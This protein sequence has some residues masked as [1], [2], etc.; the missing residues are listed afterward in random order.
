MSGLDFQ[1]VDV[2][3]TG[4]L[5]TKTQGKL[6]IP[7]KWN[8]LE[9][10]TLS[11]DDTPTRRDGI[12]ALVAAATG[13][14][15]ATYNDELLV[16]KG[17]GVKSISTAGTDFANAVPGKLGFVNVAK[18]EIRRS[19]GMQEA[20]DVAT[21]GGL[22]CYVWRELTSAAVATG[23]NMSLLDEATGTQIQAN[24]VLHANTA[25]FCP[26]V[27]FCPGIVVGQGAFFIFY[28][29]GTSLYGRV[30]YSTSPTVLGAETAL[31]TSANLASLNFDA[32]PFGL[33][34]LLETTAMV[35]YGWADGTTSVRTIQVNQAAGVPAILTGP[36][37]IITEAALPIATLC[38]IGVAQFSAVIAVTFTVASA[39]APTLSGLAGVTTDSA[40]AVLTAATQIDATAPA[41]VGNCH[42]AACTDWSSSTRVA[43]FY[44][45]QMSFS[46]A[47]TAL[48]PIRGSVLLNNLTHVAGPV[49]IMN[50]AGF[51]GAATDPAGPQGPWIAGK[52]FANSTATFLPVCVLENYQGA[53]FTAPGGTRVTNNQQN[54]LFLLDCTAMSN[55]LPATVVAKA[56]Y[57]S[58]GVAAINNNPPRISTACSTPAPVSG[59]FALAC[60]ER[61]LL[62]FVDGFNISP[63]GVVRLTFT[64]NTTTPPI[65]TQLGELT[66]LA[67][68]SLTT[69][70]GGALVEHGFPL[71]PEG[72]SVELVAAGGAMTA[73]VHQVV[74]IAEW[75]DNAGERHQSKPSLA[76][77]MTVAANDRLRVRVPSL[78]L[79]Q[80]TGVMFVAYVTQAAGLTFNR[81]ATVATG[82]GG[83]ANDPTL[84]F[85]TLALIDAADATYASNELLYTQPNLAG[86][87][88]PNVAPGPCSALASH[89]NR[90]FFDRADQPCQFGFTQRY[91]N[92]LGLQCNPALGGSWDISGGSFVG[93]ASMDE[94]M[95]LFC[96][97]K[98]FVI[99][100]TG[101]DGS[102]G[103]SNYG[104]PQEISSDAGCV[105]ARSILKMPHGIIFK[106]A[107]G[108]YLL[109]RD[110]QVRYIGE[111]VAAFDANSVSSAVLLE[112]R[113]ECRFSST[114][115]TQLIYSY[116]V[117]GDGQWSTTVYRADSG[118]AVTN[119]AIADAIWWATGGYYAT[120][121]LVHGLN[122]DTAGVFLDQPGTSPAALAIPTTARTAWLRMAI[123]N[124][125]QRVRRFFLTGTSPNAPTSTLTVTVDFDDAYG[126]VVAGSYQFTV[127]YGT[128]FP[129][130]LVGS[131]VDIRH[132][133]IHQKC[134]SVSFTFTDTPTTANPAGVNLQALS[135][136]LGL[137]RGLKKLPAA[138]TV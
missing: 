113:M 16:V 19:T 123:I 125:Y 93:W 32:Q 132:K 78:L 105:D 34:G 83:T 20:L 117:K 115:G 130:F 57:G 70:D 112:D 102:G 42:V 29:R 72:V 110:L 27:V 96:T 3:F 138:Q 74:V 97:R 47:A 86:T 121:S 9:N 80:K 33:N 45:Q 12:A 56:L 85:T 88:L 24:V 63:T 68:G 109:G 21:G 77:S 98:P 4:G 48:F 75:I 129:T 8:R 92:N 107:K 10:C 1:T 114:S 43:V 79:S 59:A 15:L 124:G 37:N 26:R 91:V 25:A 84:A 65:R 106:S 116:D 60:T 64:P 82:S 119:V 69:Y 30:I 18:K 39:P 58:F 23:I 122:K 11:E 76:V 136:E 94:K 133:L 17:S 51:A 14:G 90:I 44:D 111:G 35:S 108:W 126:F 31:I 7:S 134:K 104:E 67:G 127:N 100:G 81:V 120:V 13:N 49:T 54:T 103:F 6:V 137:K 128:V 73:G 118:A 53:A 135:L 28:I 66:F 40:W 2:R 62:S 38:G 22:T 36:T 71:F 95:I 52:P 89:Q 101:P 41:A 61:T 50:S 131:S 5:D 99:Y 87:T 46:P 55:M